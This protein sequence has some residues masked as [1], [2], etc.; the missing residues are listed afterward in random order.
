MSNLKLRQLDVET[1][2]LSTDLEA[3]ADIYIDLPEPI[4]VPIGKV[5]KLKKS[6]YMDSS[7]HQELE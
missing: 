5:F 6:H 7:K 1:A 2:F 4:Q 3:G